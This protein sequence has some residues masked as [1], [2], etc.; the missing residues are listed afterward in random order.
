MKLAKCWQAKADKGHEDPL[1]VV[2]GCPQGHKRHTQGRGS[3]DE[4]E[5]L[6][7]SFEMGAVRAL[8]YFS[9]SEM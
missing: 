4:V 3:R 8:L 9:E 5:G 1:A 6:A 7:G 2:S